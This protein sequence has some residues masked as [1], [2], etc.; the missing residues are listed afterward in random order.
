MTVSQRE[1]AAGLQNAARLIGAGEAAAAL[2]VLD[3]LAMS[4]GRHPDILQI[5]GVALRRL[6]RLAEAV[7]QFRQS[8]SLH[9]GQPHVH[10]N[11]ASALLAAGQP[12]EAE[13]HFRR[14]LALK[15]DYAEARYNLALLI[16]DDDPAAA[17]DMLG[18]VTKSNPAFGPAWEALAL[19]LGK[20]GERESALAAAR[21]AVAQSPG[22]HTA[23]HNLG[24]AAMAM[25]DYTSAE[26]AYARSVQLQPRSDAGWFGLG[27]A[28]RSQE[29]HADAA[30]AMEKA[31]A[32]NPGNID[33]HRVLNELLWQTGQGHHY[34]QSFARALAQ[35]PGNTEL[36]TA[37][38]AGLLGIMRPEEA[39]GVLEP[40]GGEGAA[41]AQAE[42]IRARAHAMLGDHAR[43]LQHHAQ[44]V[45]CCPGDMI[46]TR[47]GIET[48]LKAGRHD[49]AMAA[50]ERGLAS[51]P[52]DQGLLAMY[53][54]ALRLAGDERQ[55]Q[56]ADFHSLARVFAL[57][58][59][60]GFASMED[61]NL[62]LAEELRKLH[63]TRFH[64]TDQ[65]LRG[66]TQT[67][68][69]LFE[70]REPL[71]QLLRAQLEKAIGA[72]I[73]DMREDASHPLFARRGR[74]FGFSG[75]WSVRLSEGGFHT[76]H[77]HPMGWISSAYYVT[78]PAESRDSDAK[79][80]W[81]KLGE[82]NLGL[83]ENERIERYVQAQPGHL[84]LFPSY[85]WHGTVPF[86]AR[87]ERITVAFDVVPV[88]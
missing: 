1:L 80:G 25:R 87:D 4:V 59:P 35:S 9:D 63:T 86:N 31:V 73:S 32:A 14:A 13:R 55:L 23:Q 43:A 67:F 88:A 54:T 47:H 11:L 8:L 45:K 64:P 66:G 70:R 6:G 17:R 40:V 56:L 81:F 15:P 49:E 76:N 30:L 51:S 24:Q 38:A 5:R 48:M 34:L 41:A 75:S 18:A 42:D 36:R 58:P 85:F 61:F 21:R 27:S 7:E 65:T 79:P 60:P 78:V 69:A 26:Q 68:G 72:Y 77:F 74:N 52:F 29:R 19:A 12:G 83:G 84:V 53:T 3:G 28:L 62:A 16:L 22:S 2:Q 57:D 10:N 39:L 20:L 44:A 82:T 46:I 50:C 33:A 71:V 37:Y